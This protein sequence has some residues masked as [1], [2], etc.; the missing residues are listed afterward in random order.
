[1]YKRLT[2]FL[3][4]C[5]IN[6]KSRLRDTIVVADSRKVRICSQDSTLEETL[7]TRISF[8]VSRN[9]ANFY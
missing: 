6:A 3:T 2:N 9:F 5:Y 4:A 8:E 7:I 1:M